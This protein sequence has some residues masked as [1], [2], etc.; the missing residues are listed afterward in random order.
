MLV[1]QNSLKFTFLSSQIF[2]NFLRIFGIFPIISV[3]QISL[4]IYLN[5]EIN[6]EWISFSFSFPA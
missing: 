3:T 1:L 6:F 4:L 2:Y 5:L